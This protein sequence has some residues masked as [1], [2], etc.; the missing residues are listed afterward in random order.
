MTDHLQK[1]FAD[2]LTVIQKLRQSNEMFEEMCA[3]YEE[4]CTWLSARTRAHE[5][6]PEEQ[7]QARELIEELQ[8]EITEAI[9]NTSAQK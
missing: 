7:F 8:D 3:N 2:H 9:K 5:L 6:T 1:R 4:I